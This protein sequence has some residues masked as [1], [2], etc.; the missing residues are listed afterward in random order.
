MFFFA[1]EGHKGDVLSLAYVK[2]GG[3]GFS[4]GSD[5]ALLEWNVDVGYMKSNF[6]DYDKT[7][8][9]KE[10]EQGKGVEKVYHLQRFN[11]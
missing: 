10:H 8:M 11:I 7:T 4:G 5:G 2:S 3:I 6:S 1:R 9:A